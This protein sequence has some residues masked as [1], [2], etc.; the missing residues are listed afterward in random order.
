LRLRRLEN[1]IP[2]RTSTIALDVIPADDAVMM[3]LADGHTPIKEI[4]ARIGVEV[5][6][7]LRSF[8][9]L[10]TAGLVDVAPHAADP[11]VIDL[12]EERSLRR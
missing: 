3:S 1:Y 4:A 5:V 11:E 10:L 7:A 6:D 8:Y 9:R 2:V 12:R